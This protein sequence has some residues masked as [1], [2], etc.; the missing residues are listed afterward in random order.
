[1]ERIKVTNFLSQIKIL[2][3]LENFSIS[4]DYEIHT[5]IWMPGDNTIA[6]INE[7]DKKHKNF[8]NFWE[9]RDKGELTPISVCYSDHSKTFYGLSCT[10]KDVKNQMESK[11]F[12]HKMTIT[13]G[14]EENKLEII[15]CKEIYD[16]GNLFYFL[17]NFQQVNG[18][19]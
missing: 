1:M 15:H 2:K 11:A 5:S 6:L 17:I 10:S 12:L 4:H 7:K 14:K 8:G 19:V 9:A 13:K 3:D 18:Y 16:Q